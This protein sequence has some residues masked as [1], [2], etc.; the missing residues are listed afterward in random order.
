MSCGMSNFADLDGRLLNCINRPA[1]MCQAM[2]NEE[3]VSVCGDRYL[4]QGVRQCMVQIPAGEIQVSRCA[5][6]Q[7][8]ALTVVRNEA[9]KKPSA[10]G[11]EVRV[12]A[13]PAEDPV[14]T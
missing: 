8:A 7:E 14:S 5:S 4:R 12:S 3:A 1:A 9:H 6:F 13:K 2:S 11:D 10:T